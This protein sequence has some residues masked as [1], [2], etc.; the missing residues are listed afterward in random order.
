[1]SAKKHEDCTSRWV[2]NMQF[3]CPDRRVCFRWAGD[4]G[5]LGNIKQQSVKMEAM[6]LKGCFS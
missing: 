2:Q 3:R 5:A 6:F 1:M 4:R